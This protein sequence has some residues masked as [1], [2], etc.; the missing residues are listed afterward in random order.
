MVTGPFEPPY[1]CG[2]L[3]K[4]DDHICTPAVLRDALAQLLPSL[5]MDPQSECSMEV[6]A[7]S[8]SMTSKLGKNKL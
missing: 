8:P 1:W 7:C 2:S 3:T 5:E 4:F 6:F